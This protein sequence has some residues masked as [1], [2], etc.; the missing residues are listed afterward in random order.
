MRTPSAVVTGLLLATLL[1]GCGYE[2]TPVP[3]PPEASSPPAPAPAP[4]CTSDV[5]PLA[6]YPPS[7]EVVGKVAEIRDRGRLVVGVSADTY[8]MAAFDPFSGRIE[9]FDIEFAKRVA[10]EIFGPTFSPGANL[11]LRVITAAERI[12]ALQEGEVDLVVRNM[13]INCDR[14]TDVAF[15][16]VYYAATQKVLVSEE[17]ADGDDTTNGEYD[18]PADLAGLRVCAPTGSTSL[19]NITDAEPEAIIEP[20]STHTGCLVKF[21]QGEVDAITGDDTVLAGLAAQDPYAVVPDQEPFSNEPYGIAA[22]SQDVELVQFVNAVLEEMRADGSWQAAYD[23][24]LAP[25]LGPADPALNPPTPNYDR[26][27]SWTP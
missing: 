18:S 26:P 19:V 17:L 22:K 9:G 1:A 23:R 5:D 27:V 7:D 25:R 14:W 3:G 6:S 4:E 8:R 16:S 21:Q 11:Q 15:S 13:T 20:A 2:A 10:A 24:W 12:P